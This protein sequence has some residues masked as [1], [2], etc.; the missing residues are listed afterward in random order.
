MKKQGF[1]GLLLSLVGVPFL[2]L[3]YKFFKKGPSEPLTVGDGMALFGVQ[4]IIA[5]GITIYLLFFHTA[6]AVLG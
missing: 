3:L 6:Q 4:V 5:V 1:V 2:M